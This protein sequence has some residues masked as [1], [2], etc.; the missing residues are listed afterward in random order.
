VRLGAKLADVMQQVGLYRWPRYLSDLDNR[1][2]GWESEVERNNGP[3]S[4]GGTRP[5]GIQNSAR[6]V[7][8][9]PSSASRQAV[10]ESGHDA[11]GTPRPYFVATPNSGSP[12]TWYVNPGSGQMRFFGPDGF[13]TVDIDSDH[14]HG[15]GI[16][17][18][19]IWTPTP[20]EYPSRGS[21]MGMPD[22]W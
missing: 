15:Q 6:A 1:T 11:A 20:D 5:S 19:H 13:P 14:D 22:G 8:S 4:A 2:A 21:G 10:R 12:N 7:G 17:H 3:L 18:L 9:V 16:P